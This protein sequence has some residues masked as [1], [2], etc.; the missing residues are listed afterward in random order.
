MYTLHDSFAKV[1]ANEHII[2]KGQNREQRT[3]Q[4]SSYI[5][6]IVELNIHP[7]KCG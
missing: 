1:L 2:S 6:A 4:R 3:K 5:M 7:E